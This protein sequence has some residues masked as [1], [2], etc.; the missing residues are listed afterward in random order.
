MK[1]ATTKCLT[2]MLSEFALSPAIFR[3]ASYESA[4]VADL[5]LRQMGQALR[6]NGIV[7]NMCDG[8]WLN[9]ILQSEVLLHGRAKELLK[10]LKSGNRLAC[11]PCAGPITP[12]DDLSWEVEAL[13]PHPK[14]PLTGCIFSQ[15]AKEIRY[16][17]NPLVSCPEKLL[18][19]P[20]WT[21]RACSCRISRSNVAYIE[22][23]SPLLRH[24]N[25]IMFIDPHIDPSAKRYSDFWEI[26]TSAELRCRVP[27]ATIEIHRVAWTGDSNDRRP[28]VHEIKDAF[29]DCLEKLLSKAGITVEVF[30][31]DDFHDRFI[32]SE[33]LGMSW[34][35]GFDTSKDPTASVTI[36]RLSQSDRDGVQNEFSFNSNRHHLQGRFKI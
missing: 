31:W 18:S 3:T 10:K 23:L 4:T 26:V 28:R 27:K 9:Q 1:K 30:L 25:S 5:C 29:K 13:M 14:R 34:S 22:L 20:F 17:T 35:N 8:E 12:D 2:D 15:Q 32:V 11:H 7:R 33:L 16:R 6:E 19:A 24:A 36:A 21:T